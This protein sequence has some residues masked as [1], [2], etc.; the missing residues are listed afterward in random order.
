MAV[1]KAMKFGVF[2][3]ISSDRL[4]SEGEFY[5]FH[6]VPMVLRP[7]QLPHPPIWY[8]VVDP[9]A[10]QWPHSKKRTS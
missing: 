5:R 9:E 7:V 10:T 3:H 2:D 4:T 6:D 1:A 8:G